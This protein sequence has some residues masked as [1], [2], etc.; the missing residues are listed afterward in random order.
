MLCIISLEYR[1]TNSLKMWLSRWGYH[2]HL[3]GCQACALNHHTN[4]NLCGIL[5][6]PKVLSQLTEWHK[7]YDTHFEMV[8]LSSYRERKAGSKSL[9]QQRRHLARRVQLCSEC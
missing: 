3:L 6:F 8:Y 2:P 1:S 4:S 9:L 7:N 5:K